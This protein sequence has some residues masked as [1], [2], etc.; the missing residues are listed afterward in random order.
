MI[1]RTICFILLLSTSVYAN[2]YSSLTPYSSSSLMTIPSG[3]IAARTTKTIDGSLYEVTN[4]LTSIDCTGG[5]GS[6]HVTCKYDSNVSEWIAIDG[7]VKGSS[8]ST[9]NAIARYSG[10]TGKV[11]R[12]SGAIV[13]DNGNILGNN[14]SGVNTGDQDLTA[15]ALK[16]NVLELNNTV[17]FIPDTQYEPATKG[18]VDANHLV[19]SV[20]LKTGAVIL[21]SDDISD[22]TSSQK[23]IS[24]TQLSKLDA[25]EANAKDDQS[26][27]EVPFTP[28]GSI[29]ATNVQ[30]AIL[31]VRDE[32][33]N[34]S[35]DM[36]TNT[37]QD[38]TGIKEFQD[39]I[40]I[41]FGS[42]SDFQL[43]Y[44]GIT[45][46]QLELASN[47]ATDTTV[48]I[49]N[50]GTGKTNLKIDGSI[51][52]GTNG[53]HQMAASNP[54]G[55]TGSNPALGGINWNETNHRYEYYNGTSWLPLFT[56]EAAWT[57]TDSDEVIAIADGKQ[58]FPIPNTDQW[59]NMN[60]AFMTC[61]VCDLNSASGGNTTV[62]L[63]R[64]R[65][66][67]EVDMTSTGVTISYDEYYASDAV[68]DVANDDINEGDKL[69]ID[70]NTIT[71][72]AAQKGLS[73]IVG[74]N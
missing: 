51:T 29:E 21:D 36:T 41:I 66:N 16:S 26:S 57:I 28:N 72:G 33:G 1:F 39:N 49:S 35:G 44:D 48:N 73:C 30:A 8:S 4:G 34:G 43:R 2:P 61:S 64:V 14:L 9:H 19:Y 42:D 71:T 45:N 12:N 32:A 31:E 38:V 6:Y 63:R 13:D 52:A 10:T 70:V 54:S 74:F 56:K 68:I 53:N 18:Y 7:D 24:A 65:G 67:T 62:V 47:N 59:T 3:T 37:N 5:G 27:T 46:H 69:Y 40:P 55:Y 20:N 11:I 50:V 22:S 15:L 60:L 25:I 58:A 23:F 17:P